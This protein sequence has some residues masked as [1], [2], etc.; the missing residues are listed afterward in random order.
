MGT[1][2]ES[3]HR[4]KAEEELRCKFHPHSRVNG[5]AVDEYKGGK[6]ADAAPY[7]AASIF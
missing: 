2:T 1:G 6:S 4:C 5:A 3:H 7:I